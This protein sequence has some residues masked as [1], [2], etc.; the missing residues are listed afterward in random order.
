MSADALKWLRTEAT[1]F[2]DKVQ[3]SEK[4]LWEFRQENDIVS[5]EER[6][7]IISQRI[8]DLTTAYTDIRRKRIEA[9]VLYNRVKQQAKSASRSEAIPAVLANSLIQDL[10]GEE[11]RL[12]RTRAELANKYGPKHPG[13]D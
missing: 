11:I 13:D 8:A 7:D 3:E 4:A 12:E 9:E 2:R 10:K 1:S 6:Q 5:F